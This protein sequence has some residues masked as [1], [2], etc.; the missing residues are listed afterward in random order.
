MHRIL[1]PLLLLGLVSLCPGQ[2]WTRFRGPNGSG[3]SEAKSVPVKWTE[4]DYRW[5]VKLPG[6]GWGSPVVWGRRLFVLAEEHDG[7]AR[8]VLCI[9]TADGKTQWE[10]RFDS[11]SHRKHKRNSYATSTPAV[12][13]QRVYVA[14]GTPKKLTLMALTHAGKIVW[15]KDLGPVK[16]G[17][18]F[19]A[20]PIVYGDLVVLANDQNGR[21][22]LIAVNRETGRIAWNVPRHSKRL[23]YSTPCV[24]E[25]RG[26]TP[27]LIFTNWRHG[28]TAI[29]PATGRTNW[30]VSVFNQSTKER[31]IG[32]PVL[33]GELIIATCGFTNNPK[34]TVA[35]RPGDGA[36]PTV[37]EVYRVERNVPHIPSPLVYRNRLYLWSDKGIVACYHADTGK[38]VWQKRV[39]GNFFGSPVCVDGRLYAVDDRGNVVVLAAGDTFRLL[40]KNALGEPCQSTPAVSGGTMFIRTQ[41]HLIALGGKR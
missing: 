20:S 4:S 18:G 8:I 32:S 34:H 36:Q 33:A 5:K 16:G 1:P 12:D 39:G 10:R 38:L 24:Y 28:I 15:E 27:E 37:R 41:S 35:V 31:A 40:A 13:E 7:A 26:R 9:N 2:E 22:S 25:R 30:E 29:D 11:T 17:H 23:T 21:S 19:G 3:I 14:W 6:R